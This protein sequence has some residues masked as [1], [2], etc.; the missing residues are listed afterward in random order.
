MNSIR[1]HWDQ[2][3]EVRAELADQFG[4]FG[5]IYLM[6]LKR[7]AKGVLPGRVCTAT[8]HIAAMCISQDTH[9]LA[10]PEEIAAWKHQDAETRKQI[11]AEK[12]RT[13]TKVNVDLGDQFVRALQQVASMN[14]PAAVPVPPAAVGPTAKSAA[15]AKSFD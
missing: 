2:I 13:D 8:V 12:A 1:E 4:E 14:A 10:T 6:S 9:R 3:K 11:L 5:T 7:R 15:T